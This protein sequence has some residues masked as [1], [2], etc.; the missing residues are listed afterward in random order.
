MTC[1]LIGLTASFII[2]ICQIKVIRDPAPNEKQCYKVVEIGS[3]YDPDNNK[4]RGYCIT[5]RELQFINLHS[6]I[7]YLLPE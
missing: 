3:S 6:T 1:K 5:E 4:F 2:N 7:E